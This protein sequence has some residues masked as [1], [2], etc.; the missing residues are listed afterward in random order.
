MRVSLLLAL[1]S[2]SFASAGVSAQSVPP[3]IFTDPPAD[4][5]HT[6]SLVA[7]IKANGGTKITALHVDTDHG[8]S[9]HRIALESTV[10]TWL[11]GLH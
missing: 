1:V 11:A 6:D 2:S 10:I 3:A 5:A 7:A 9:D 4:S 8:W